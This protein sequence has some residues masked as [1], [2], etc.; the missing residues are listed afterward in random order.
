MPVFYFMFKSQKRMQ[1]VPK[2]R[3]LVS[4]KAIPSNKRPYLVRGLPG[5]VLY[6][7]ADQAANRLDLIPQFDR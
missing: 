4:L 7:N 3:P 6:L 5:T 2:K 1:F